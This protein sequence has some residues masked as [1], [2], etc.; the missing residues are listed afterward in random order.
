MSSIQ[1]IALITGAARR[2]GA[3]IATSLHQAGYGV[4]LHYRQSAESAERLAAR[5]N[6]ERADS[7]WVMQADL[8]S[9][10]QMNQLVEQLLLSRGRLDVLVNNASSFYPTPMGEVSEQQ[11]DDLLGSNLKAPFFLSQAAFPA[12][13]KHEGCIV[14]IVDI[15]AQRAL[16]SYPV[17]S[18]AKAGLYALTETLAKELAPKVRV[19]AVSPGVIFWPENHQAELVDEIIKKVPLQRQGQ[20]SDIAETVLFLVQKANYITGQ[21]IAVDGGK[22]LV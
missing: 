18:S 11:W 16:P 21:I 12:L 8:H 17:Y 20:A 19:N 3:A 9:L 7:A 6:A 10:E 15:Y 13:A 4:V 22:G 1:K 5:L 14:N 2:I